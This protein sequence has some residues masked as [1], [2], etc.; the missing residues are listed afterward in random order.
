MNT[1]WDLSVLYKGF[2][3]PAIPADM[4][5]VRERLSACEQLLAREGDDLPVLEGLVAG[6]NEMLLLFY[7]I[8]GYAQLVLSCDTTHPEAM[9]LRE[10]MMQ[11][12]LEVHPCLSAM[13][14]RVAAAG[15]LEEL[16]SSSALL[17]E[18][19]YILR[20]MKRAALHLLPPEL[21]IPV[22]RMQLTGG[23]AFSQLREQMESSIIVR[24]TLDGE[25]RELPLPAARGL[26]YSPDPA[27]RKAAYVAELA[28]YPQ[29]EI[30]VAACLNAIKGEA[31]TLC[32]L[33]QYESVL[34]KT[35]TESRM[36][37][38]TL[39][40]MLDAIREFL[41]DF[42]RYLKAKA[43]YLGHENGLPFWELF[44]PVGEAGRVYTLEEA[45]DTLV[46]VMGKFSPEM[47]TFVAGAFDNAWIDPLPKPGK[48]GGAF[49]ASLPAQKESRILSNFDG[50][51]SAVSTLAHELG[52]AYHN[53]QVRDV[54]MLNLNTPA[55]LA[56]TASIF[57]ETFFSHAILETAS[58]EETL[59]YLESE[60][61]EQCQVIVDIYSRYLFETRVI[62]QREDRTMAAEELC[63]MMLQAQLDSYGDGL[64][65]SALHPYMW[66]CKS[67][68]YS[69][70]LH[71]YNFPYAFGLLFGKG[72][73]ARYLRGKEDFVPEYNR[74][75]A[76]TG[77]DSVAGVAT[78]LGI[79]VREKAFWRSALSGI[80]ANIDR[81]IALTEG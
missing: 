81:F 80:K 10:R 72:V 34:D 36:D 8:Y 17:T 73:F 41:P 3:D 47:G 6:V 21:E 20:E 43:K 33:Q 16:I 12:S 2:D 24:L 70:G 79:D 76:S 71:F 75:L 42:R 46:T 5:K 45:R 68:Y 7:S 49:C 69:T 63:E 19:A 15:D 53:Y 62:E 50:S 54:T 29:A 38:E 58:P 59:V 31:L 56:E 61:M 25:E 39:E 27:V 26:A 23:E 66:L 22:L 48:V 57:N 30:A 55:C 74:L 32:K 37:R 52:H 18:H 28:A 64:D 67:H 14:R 51:H 40:A 44:A 11:M 65:T 13:T 77:L 35:L 9:A 1:H 4:A 60:L 78:R